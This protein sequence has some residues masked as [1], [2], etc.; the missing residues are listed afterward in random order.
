MEKKPVNV[1]IHDISLKKVVFDLQKCE[2]NKEYK[3]Q[4][5]DEIEIHLL[6]DVT[7]IVVFTRK[8]IDI[9]PFQLEISYGATIKADK[10]DL[11]ANNESISEFAD[12]KKQ[13]IV[14]KLSFPSRVSVLISEI[15]RESGSVLVTIPTIISTKKEKGENDDASKKN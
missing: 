11:N 6:D 5:I 4:F 8:A 1:K 15:T 10:I 7:F 9:S 13:D 12:R 2:E 3:I 14:H